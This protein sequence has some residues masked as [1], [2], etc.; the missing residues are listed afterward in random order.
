[1]DRTV[2][3]LHPVDIDGNRV[4]EATQLSR[5]MQKSFD[6]VTD[7]VTKL[8]KRVGKTDPAVSGDSYFDEESQMLM[9]YSSSAQE[10][11]SFAPV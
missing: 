9:V 1:M 10:W 2:F 6:D 8:E 5:V 7:A 3:R 4:P 11:L